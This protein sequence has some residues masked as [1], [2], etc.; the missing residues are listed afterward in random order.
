[1]NNL[2]IK[3]KKLFSNKN[4][5]TALCFVL[6]AVVLIIGYNYRINEKTKPV[7]IPY[8]REDVVIPPQSEITEE[9]IAYKEVANNAINK[10]IMYVSTKNIIGKYTKL[11]STLYGGSFF[12]KEAIDDKENLPTS[13]LL[14]T[15]EGKTLL[16]MKVDMESSYFN[17]L[18]PGDYF[19]LYVN[20][21]GVL[22]EKESKKDEIIVGKLISAIEILAVKDSKGNNVFSGSESGDPAAVIFAV[23]DD[24]ALLI[25]KAN[26]FSKLSNDLTIEFS[27]I[28]RGQAY[29]DESGSKV[30]TQI[31]SEKLEKYIKEK[32]AEV[33]IKNIKNPN[34]IGD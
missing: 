15:E 19:D 12:Y 26:Y 9:M 25:M 3:I 24:L 4:V 1:M 33:D 7:K 20:T 28:P 22:D 2:S 5:V 31:S 16:T 14:G 17:M 10:E 29:V 18:A 8:V 6:I 11:N 34:E 30:E 13:A 21:I 27:I 23:P 32:T